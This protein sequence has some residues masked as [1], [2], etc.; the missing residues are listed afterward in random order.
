M[1]M[2]NGIEY[3]IDDLEAAESDFERKIAASAL[4]AQCR[5][6]VAMCAASIE[7]Y[8]D[9]QE[10]SAFERDAVLYASVP[11]LQATARD[12]MAVINAL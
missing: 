8:F 9:G 10:E 5:G 1:G 12:L 6:R 2:S 4:L 7:W 3:T 11:V